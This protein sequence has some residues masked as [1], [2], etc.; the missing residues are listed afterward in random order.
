MNPY[1]PSGGS[2]PGGL[3]LLAGGV[4]I[5]ALCTGAVLHIV[6]QWINLLV[7]FPMVA[8]AAV[9]FAAAA[10]VKMR[11]IRAPL[12]VG[13]LA[14]VGALL[15]WSTDMG[16]GYV[17]M[18]MAFSEEIGKLAEAYES[19]TEDKLGADALARTIDVVFVALGS[20]EE[21][22]GAA[23]VATLTN[24]PFPREDGTLADPVPRPAFP[25]VVT[26]YLRFA[27]AEGTTI[28]NNGR[29][30]TRVG[31]TGTG[32][33]WGLEVLLMVAVAVGIA[34]ARASQPFC[35]HCRDWYGDKEQI[36]VVSADTDRKAALEAVRQG[37]AAALALVANPNP[38]PKKFVTLH[39]RK[40]PTC[41]A[42]PRYVRLVRNKVS[43][44]KN[45]QSNLAKGMVDGPVF[46]KLVAA[47]TPPPSLRG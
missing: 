16:I 43:G 47:L 17:R 38:D 4:L 36:F 10:I 20:G 6:S 2:E 3:P 42:S 35:E 9:G 14:L 11:K 12:L 26:G 34:F 46:D 23:L 19:N 32:L 21:P 30:E 5:A 44:R 41:A 22:D 13:G 1:Q 40:C 25:A 45:N 18:R 28:Q 33:L 39:L 15:T 7:V 29:S 8:G 31:A 24:E 37:D 27:A